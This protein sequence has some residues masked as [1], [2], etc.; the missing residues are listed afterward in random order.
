MESALSGFGLAVEEGR[1]VLVSEKR[2]FPEVRVRR[3]DQRPRLA[4]AFSRNI[5]PGRM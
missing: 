2:R 1:K 3:F 4:D 5:S